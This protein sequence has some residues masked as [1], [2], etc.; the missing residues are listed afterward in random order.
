MGEFKE[1]G[2]EIYMEIPEGMQKWCMKFSEPVVAKLKKCI[3]GTKQAAKYCYTKIVFIKCIKCERSSTDPCLFFKCDLAWGLVMW[4][5]GI[6]DKLC[7]ANT[8]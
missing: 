1:D 3:Y 7:I 5:T 2:P 4:L 8:R 6:N